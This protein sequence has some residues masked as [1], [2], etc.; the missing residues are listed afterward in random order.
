MQIVHDNGHLISTSNRK[1]HSGEVEIFDSA[2]QK[3]VSTTVWRQLVTML[4]TLQLRMTMTKV[5]VQQ[6]TGGSDCGLFAIGFAAALVH[7]QDPA[8]LTFDQGA[9]QQF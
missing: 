3:E 1:C 6:Q 7:G 5:C 2:M 9:M 8:C 4:H